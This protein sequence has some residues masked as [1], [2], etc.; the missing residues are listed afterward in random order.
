MSALEFGSPEANAFLRRDKWKR[1]ME[2]TCGHVWEK[3]SG[4][5]WCDG[6][7]RM[8]PPGQMKKR[9]DGLAKKI[10]MEPDGNGGWR[11]PDQ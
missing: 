11:Y 8:M 4:Y 1:R 7:Q 6:C 5:Y 3:R 2:C 9:I 10:G